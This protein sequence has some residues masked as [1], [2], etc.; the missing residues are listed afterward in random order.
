MVICYKKKK[1]VN[2]KGEV[3]NC[4]VTLSLIKNTNYSNFLTFLLPSSLANSILKSVGSISIRLRI[5]LGL[6]HADSTF[7]S[8]GHGL[9]PWT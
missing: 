7:N 2:R 9:N 8:Q 3:D 6:G 1:S 5:Y 4:L